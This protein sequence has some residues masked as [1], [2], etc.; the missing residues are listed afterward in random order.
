MVKISDFRLSRP[1]D[2]EKGLSGTTAS[3]G[4]IA[5][6]SKDENQSVSSSLDVFILGCFFHYVLSATSP[7]Q[8][9]LH[10]FGRTELNRENNIRDRSFLVYHS[11]WHPAEIEDEK[12]VDLIKKMI[13]W[14][15]NTRPNLH[16]VLSHPYFQSSTIKEYYPIHEFKKPGLCVIF[17]QQIFLNVMKYLL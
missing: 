17:N 11:V 10:P 15:E 8:K 1:L 3:E 4:W 5:P 14:K 16:H 7:S 9:P 12:A 13:Q 6:E 2:P